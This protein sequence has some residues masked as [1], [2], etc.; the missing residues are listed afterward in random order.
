MKL[1]IIFLVLVFIVSFI[2]AFLGVDAL[3]TLLII[4]GIAV[5][6]IYLSLSPIVL[7]NNLEKVERFLLN[8]QDTPVYYFLYSVAN[9]ATDDVEKAYDQV[10]QKYGNSSKRPL[11]ELIYALYKDNLP[12]AKEHLVNI[13]APDYQDYYRCAILLEEGNVAKAREIGERLPKKWMKATV[14]AEV[15]KKEGNSQA[16]RE[17][18]EEAFNNARGIQKYSV[19]KTFEGLLDK[20]LGD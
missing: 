12:E 1:N 3:T 17:F 13:K 2:L 15:S 5:I 6:Y 8:N 18:A 7:S 14:L 16:A 19:Y 11:F 9:K 20:K 4:F 10:L